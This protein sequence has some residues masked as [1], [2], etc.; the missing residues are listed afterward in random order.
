MIEISCFNTLFT[1]LHLESWGKMV[2]TYVKHYYSF[3]LVTSQWQIREAKN[4][5]WKGWNPLLV[6]GTKSTY[7]ASKQVKA[8]EQLYLNATPTYSSLLILAQSKCEKNKTSRFHFQH[9]IFKHPILSSIHHKKEEWVELRSKLIFWT[10]DH[11]L[12]D[13]LWDFC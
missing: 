6:L 9:S 8:W 7:H 5:D 12:I 11:L 13:S 1:V 4:G 3:Y 10:Q 2:K